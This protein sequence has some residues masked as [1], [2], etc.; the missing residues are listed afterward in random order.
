M[1]ETKIIVLTEEELEKII[2]LGRLEHYD[3]KIKNWVLKRLSGVGGI[4]NLTEE[5]LIEMIR[6]EIDN[7]TALE[8]I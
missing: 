6:S 3:E 1:A 4:G 5:D 7:Y 2:N 8:I